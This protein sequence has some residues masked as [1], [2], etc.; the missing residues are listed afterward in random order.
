[1]VKTI[2]MSCPPCEVGASSAEDG[3]VELYGYFSPRVG[4]TSSL[5]VLFTVEGEDIAEV[6]A[7]VFVSVFARF[8]IN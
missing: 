8:S 5:P 4:D 2:P 6:M 7:P 1:M 3:E